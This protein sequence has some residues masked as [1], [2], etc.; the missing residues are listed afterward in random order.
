[1][2]KEKLSS[3]AF[4][5][6]MPMTLVGAMVEDKPNFMAAAWVSRVNN[7]PPMMAVAIGSHHTNAGI[8]EHRAFSVN[9]PS[10]DMLEVTD[11]CGLVSGRKVDKSELFTLFYGEL[12]HAPMIEA[13]PVS[14]ACRLVQAVELPSNTLFI[15]EIVEAFASAEVVTD[16][17]PDIEKMRPFTLTMP[18]NRYWT[19]G[20]V[21][22]RAWGSGR[23]YAERS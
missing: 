23:G 5:Y 15:G 14:L 10:L 22:G 7:R 17:K 12:A 8:H 21:A 2:E 13:C 11:Y 16:G 4:V 6:P 9:I 19:V 3:N 1:M 20:E 18:D